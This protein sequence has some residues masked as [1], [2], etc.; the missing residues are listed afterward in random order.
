[1]KKNSIGLIVAILLVGTMVVL[2]VKSNMNENKPLE[3]FEEVE[4]HRKS[5]DGRDD[6]S[7]DIA[8]GLEQG[9]TPPDFELT[10]LTGEILTLSELKGK[11]VILNFWASWCGPCKAEM[12]HM[13]NYYEKYKDE[14]NVE[15]VAVNMTTQER[16]GIE[17]IEQFVEEYGLTFPIP[18]D[19]SGEV[20]DAYRVMTIPTTYMIGTDGTIANRM[21]GP[22]D[23]KT[24]QNLV[25]QLD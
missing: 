2:M 12:P 10:T 7:Q 4:E 8:E 15:I 13:Q 1:M 9:D 18:L 21:I 25:D 20:I 17:G 3:S 16:R 24:M 19:E 6:L 23:E 14:A 11:K 5:L 22:M